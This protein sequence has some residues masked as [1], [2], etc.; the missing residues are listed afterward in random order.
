M[1]APHNAW[2]KEETT[3]IVRVDNW[4]DA[5]KEIIKIANEI[6]LKKGV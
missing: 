6:L 1:T 2:F 4:K 3:D 5:Y